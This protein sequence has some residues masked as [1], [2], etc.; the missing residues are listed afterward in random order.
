VFAIEMEGA[1]QADQVLGLVTAAVRAVGYM[2][3]SDV[4]PFAHG[5]AALKAVPAVNRLPL[6]AVAE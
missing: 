2:V 6:A 4:L 1:A 5:A 3:E